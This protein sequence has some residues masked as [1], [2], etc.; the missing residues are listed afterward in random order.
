MKVLAQFVMGAAVRG[1]PA[2]GPPRGAAAHPLGRAA[3]HTP[4]EIFATYGVDPATITEAEEA[5][6]KGELP[7]LAHV[8]FQNYR[9]P[10]SV[11]PA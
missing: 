2:A 4:E 7:W 3:D 11:F 9:S 8:T 10:G 6:V 1:P 5:A